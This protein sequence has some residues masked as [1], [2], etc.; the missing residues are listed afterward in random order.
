MTD[1][2]IDFLAMVKDVDYVVVMLGDKSIQI[3]GAKPVTAFMKKL[4]PA[5]REHGVKRVLY[6]AGAFTRPA[7]GSLSP[8]LWCLRYTIARAFEGQHQDNEATGEFLLNECKD[9]EWS[10]HRAGIGGDTPSKGTLVRS[11]T[12]FNV[13]NHVDCAVF[14]Y[15][16]VMDD[17]AVRKTWF[18]Y[19]AT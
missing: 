12:N 14:N 16:T 9:L 3:N 17:A 19:Y 8:V 4:V 11:E 18:S 13:G 5:M 2:N 7:G 1:S 15:K 10:V 6:Q